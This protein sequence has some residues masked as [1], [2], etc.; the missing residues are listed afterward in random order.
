MLFEYFRVFTYDGN[1]LTDVSIENQDN[2]STLSG[3]IGSTNYFYLAQYYPFGNIF[4]HVDTVNDQ[5]SSW[6][7]QYW[8]GTAWRNH[9]DVLDST[10]SSGATLARSGNLSFQ[11]NDD[12]AWTA[13]TDTE[14]EG[15]GPDELNTIELKDHYWMRI[16]PT[17]NLNANTLIQEIGYAFTDTQQLND[18]DTDISNWYDAFETGKT[19]WIKE[20]KLASKL[21]VK[22][23]RRKNRIESRGELILFEDVSLATDYKTL[24]VIYRNLGEAYRQKM[25]DARDAYNS[26]IS[27]RLSVDSD[28]D[29]RLDRDEL[30]A[31]YFTMIR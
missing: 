26:I 19:D 20:I 30:R 8:D 17:A 22:D 2:S 4:F 24:E 31:K 11:A 7:P 28:H 5:N 16:S 21:V 1:T 14:E 9:V 6:T 25:L 27:T 13:V 29:G 23:L 18:I 12:Y 15:N 10:K 3:D